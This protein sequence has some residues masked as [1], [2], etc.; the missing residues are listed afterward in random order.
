MTS[1]E[2][3]LQD[4]LGLLELYVRRRALGQLHFDI[5]LDTCAV[6]AAAA[7]RVVLRDGQLEAVVMKHRHDDLH[8]ALAVRLRADERRRARVLQG[9]R[10]DFRSARAVAVNQDDD[11][12]LALLE[13]RLMDFLRAVALDNRDDGSL[14]HDEVRDLDAARDEAARVLAQIDDESLHALFSK[15]FVGG[16]ELLARVLRERSDADIAHAVLEHRA[17]GCIDLDGRALYRVVL[18][19]VAALYRQDDIRADFAADMH[20]NFLRLHLR[21]RRAVDG[22]DLVA[23]LEAGV[24]PRRIVEDG[25]DRDLAVLEAHRHADAAELALRVLLELLKLVGIHVDR[26]RVSEGLHHAGD[27]AV[28]ELRLVD[29]RHVARLDEAFDAEEADDVRDLIAVDAKGKAEAG[30]RQEGREDGR[31]DDADD[32]FFLAHVLH[33]LQRDRD[34]QR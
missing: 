13:L 33:P 23:G 22:H 31:H 15:R 4:F 18:R 10:E 9:A 25:D 8:R 17:L 16:L 5:R 1:L 20:R 29:I 7:R 28:H 12:V 27:G 2:F 14:R 6:D 32:D 3:S 34:N 21:D 24:L 11:R 19:L 30:N 26:V